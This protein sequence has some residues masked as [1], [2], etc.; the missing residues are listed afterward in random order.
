MPTYHLAGVPADVSIQNQLPP[1]FTGPWECI[2]SYK[3]MRLYI[4]RFVYIP[5]RVRHSLTWRR[6]RSAVHVSYRYGHMQV[7]AGYWTLTSDEYVY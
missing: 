4:L 6:L 2:A 1:V 7:A 3:L 5:C